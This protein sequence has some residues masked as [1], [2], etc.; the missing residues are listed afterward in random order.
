MT[1]LDIGPLNRLKAGAAAAAAALLLCIVLMLLSASSA[2]ATAKNFCYGFAA[3]G[4]PGPAYWCNSLYSAAPTFGEG[5]ITEVGGSGAQHSVCVLAW[6]GNGST[7]CSGGANQGVYNFSP[8]GGNIDVAE[9][10]NNA[11]GSNTL[12]GFADVCASPC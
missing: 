12:Y 1:Q 6:Y 9:I 10:Y 3:S 7:M 11:P 5:Y 4:R 8:S 2:S